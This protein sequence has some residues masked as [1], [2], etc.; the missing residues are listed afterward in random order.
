MNM[1]WVRAFALEDAFFILKCESDPE[2]DIDN[3][4]QADMIACIF[5]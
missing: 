2:S 5:F 3:R 4:Q 1:M